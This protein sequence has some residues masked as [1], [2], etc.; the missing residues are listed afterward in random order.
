MHVYL[1][2][3]NLHTLPNSYWK[4]IKGP[5]TQRSS[6]NKVKE[7]EIHVHEGCLQNQTCVLFCGKELLPFVH[8]PLNIRDK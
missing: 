3:C 7:Q 5:L 6:T 2:M 4:K 1:Y 8:H